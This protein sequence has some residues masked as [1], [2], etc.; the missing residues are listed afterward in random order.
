M[1]QQNWEEKEVDQAL[2]LLPDGAIQGGVAADQIA[3][4]NERKI[5]KE[6]LRV[7]H[8]TENTRFEFLIRSKTDRI[9][10]VSLD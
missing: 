7:I 2:D 6:E 3:A 10:F 8:M 4:K 9:E 5:W 1:K